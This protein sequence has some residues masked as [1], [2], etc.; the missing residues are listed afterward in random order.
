MLFILVPKIQTVEP[1][2]DNSGR[3][4]LPEL[5]VNVNTVP[6]L[7]VVVESIGNLPI[8]SMFKNKFRT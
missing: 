8:I 4:E 3:V 7:T 5:S 2:N 1:L 6:P